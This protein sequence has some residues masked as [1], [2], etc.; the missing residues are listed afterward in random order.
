MRTARPESPSWPG[1]RLLLAWAH[2]TWG[3]QVRKLAFS[4]L[5][6]VATLGG[7]GLTLGSRGAP[8]RQGPTKQLVTITNSGGEQW[9]QLLTRAQ[10]KSLLVT[11]YYACLLSLSF[12]ETAWG[13]C[14]PVGTVVSRIFHGGQDYPAIHAPLPPAACFLPCAHFYKR[15][16][17][18]SNFVELS[19]SD[20]K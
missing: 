15:S 7:V 5:A 10:S 2:Q 17:D 3:H 18:T 6:Q 1:D 11:P 12:W 8:D 19:E 9:M 20:V 13:G 4:P 14:D 16:R